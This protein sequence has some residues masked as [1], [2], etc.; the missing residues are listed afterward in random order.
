VNIET[1]IVVVLGSGFVLLIAVWI[2][3]PLQYLWQMLADA[4]D[5]HVANY[6]GTWFWRS[7]WSRQQR[8]Y[9]QAQRAFSRWFAGRFAAGGGHGL[10]DDE[11]A[12]AQQLTPII[13]QLLE[14]EVPTTIRRCNSLHRRM[15]Q[16]TGAVHMREVAGE[17]ECLTLRQWNV[18]L[19]QETARTLDHYPLSLKLDTVELLDAS[20]AIK[21][22]L[23]PTCAMCPYIRQRVADAGELC[24]A[25]RL[26]G[27]NTSHENH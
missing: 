19:L 25:A 9:R 11:L 26:I 15:A 23:L 27:I 24:P 22:N 10:D 20:V 17:P 18:L 13:R 12:A 5:E 16:L 3:P 21:K 4:L 1:L 8:H 7:M 6:T 14:E 2:I